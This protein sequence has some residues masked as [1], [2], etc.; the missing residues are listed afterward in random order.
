MANAASIGSLQAVYDT[1][2]RGVQ[3]ALNIE[4]ASLLVF[5]ASGTMRFVAWSG[6]SDTYRATVD[7]H[8]PWSATET[9]AAPLL[10]SDIEQDS[11]IADY[12]PIFRRESI[13]ALAFIPLQF[14]TRLLGKFMLYYHEPH[15]FSDVEIAIAERISAESE[16]TYGDAD[17]HFAEEIASLA[18]IAIDNAQLYRQAQEARLAA[19]TA[20]GHVEALASVSNQVA[21]SLDPDEAL[22]QLAVRVVPAFA[23]YCVTYAADE[24]GI[25]PLGYAHRDP[26]KVSL[27]ES[28]AHGL[29]VTVDDAVEPGMVIRSGEPCLVLVFS[30]A[31]AGPL[32]AGD[33][34]VGLE[35]T[36]IMTVPLNASGRTLGAIVL[37]AT[38]DSGRRFDSGDLSVAMELATRAAMLV[39]NARLYAEARSAIR[40]RDEMVAFVSHDLRDPLQSIAAATASLRLEPQ[41]LD[42]AET[43]DSIARASTQM[44]RLVQDLLDTSLLEAGR[45]SINREVV[46]LP[47]LVLELQMLVIPQIKPSGT[48]LEI[49]LAGDLPPV[50]ML[51]AS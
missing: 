35:P 49:R 27:V 11:S 1:A 43:I 39:D 38:A 20:R 47:E 15:T 3:D 25:R 2:L 21:V 30:L 23:D 4:R 44:Q 31:A 45:L 17:L 7:G 19:E 24:R 16:R 26:T 14:G 29:P 6:L 46:D 51:N 10:V 41:G 32:S 34:R 37:A 22:G 33:L 40:S 48:G 12:A 18:S 42:N 8:S 5:D 13:R 50:S 28:L 9:A 36:S